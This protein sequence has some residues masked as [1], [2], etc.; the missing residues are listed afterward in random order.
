MK[1]SGKS[2]SHRN[3]SAKRLREIAGNY[4]RQD[5]DVLSENAKTSKNGARKVIASWGLFETA[6]AVLADQPVEVPDPPSKAK[7]ARALR[8][9]INDTPNN[10]PPGVVTEANSL[11]ESMLD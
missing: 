10:L 4:A 2:T 3:A 8:S 9:L 6:I 7:A 5:V 11:I 1:R